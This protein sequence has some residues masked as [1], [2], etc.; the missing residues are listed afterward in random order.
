MRG[1]VILLFL[2]SCTYCRPVSIYPSGKKTKKITRTSM[3][4]PLG[5]L[6]TELYSAILCHIP[7]PSL[8]QT[9][10]ALSR[11]LPFAPIPLH[12]LFHSICIA[13][14]DQ[15]PRLYQRLRSG[16]PRPDEDPGKSFDAALW[17]R[18]F[19]VE[20]WQV[21]ADVLINLLRLLPN[22]ETLNLWIGPSNFAPEHLESLLKPYRPS[23][24]YLSL[25][26]RP[27][28]KK[29][30]YY[31]FLKG[32]YF[33]S[34]LLA[35]SAWPPSP[36][37][38]PTL[39]VVQDPFTPDSADMVQRFAQPIVFFRLDLH[40]SLLVHSQASSASLKSLRIRI[41]ARPIVQPLTVAYLNPNTQ[42]G[43]TITRVPPP[44]IEFLDVSTCSVSEADIEA[45]LIRFRNLQ[46]LILDGCTSLLR[47]GSP[48]ALGQDL[49][50]W[51]ALGRRCALAGV[52][53]AKDREKELKAWYETLIRNAIASSNPDAPAAD[54][55]PE[56]RRTRRGRRGLATATIS[57]RGSTSPP[58]AVPS[59]SSVPSIA[60]QRTTGKLPV[61]PK[62]HIVP[63]FPVLRTLSL[64]P[65]ST[66]NT[67]AAVSP[68]ARIQILAE[69]E[70]GWNEGIRVIWQK[71]ARMGMTFLR[72]SVE[73]AP[74]AR[75]LKFREGREEDWGAEEEGLEGLEDVGA[76]GGHM[77]FR[78]ENM[79]SG[80]GDVPVL[81]LAG[82]DMEAHGHA[83][84]CGHVSAR[85][86]WRDNL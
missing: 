26:F 7:Y 73:G 31:Q 20:N 42:N 65:A 49:Q 80:L 57:L 6:P 64:F 11:A 52:K 75:F 56:P 78:H 18:H 34:T 32:S 40:L 66:T 16:R 63:P 47:G 8:Q 25:R 69:F 45:L 53:K 5:G 9:V 68:D 21:D 43:S 48:Q 67:S 50:W 33:D 59:S 17:V 61:P 71:R 29:A 44:T 1:I 72:D 36:Q 2:R 39:S 35:L 76:G 58:R 28:V 38:L 3:S 62:I 81:C 51:S 55:L 70:K 85:D 27:Y 60:L 54:E 19:S 15:A 77:F 84:G 37:G 22:L 30:T 83:G 12:H 10:L 23:L 82:R 41:P 86:I 46:H 4:A 24:K 13:H 74:K 14:P 79:A